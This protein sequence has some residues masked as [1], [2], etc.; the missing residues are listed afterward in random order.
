MAALSEIEK[1][2]A[3]YAENPEGRY[4]A[5]LADAYRKAGRADD[6]LQ[7]VTLGL[8]KHP[9]YLSAHI[10]LGR[11]HLDKKDD[12]AAMAA[13]QSVLGLD[14]EN[15]IA[16]KSLAEISERIGQ[17]DEARRWLMRLLAVDAMNTEAEADLQRLGGPIAEGEVAEAAAPVEEAADVS[18]ADVLAEDQPAVAAAEAKTEPIPAIALESPPAAALAS[19]AVP[20]PPAAP[21]LELEPAAFQAPAE[22]QPAGVGSDVVPFDDQL[23]WGAGERQSRA[24]HAEDVAGAE[25][26]PALTSSAIEFLGAVPGG[27]PSA[28]ASPPPP[29]VTEADTLR[30][31]ALP[32]PEVLEMQA[33]SR[34]AVEIDVGAVPEA[35][36]ARAPTPAEGLPLIM[37]EDVTPPEELRRPSAK[38]VQMVSPE[39]V[40]QVAAAGAP[41]EVMVT[42]TMGDL[43]L[44]Q[45]FRS[46]AAGVY[47]RLLA[48]RPDDAGLRAKLA[49]VESPP[50]RL[51]AAA[52]GTEAVG[53]W[54]RRIAGA[55][56]GAPVPEPAPPPPEGPAPMEAAFAEPEPEIPGEPAR[57]GTDQ[58]TLDH[59]FGQGA[60]PG[61]PDEAPPRSGGSAP[62][63]G[64]SFDEFFGSAP[65]SRETVRPNE[66]EA[67][68]QPSE[69]ELSEFTAWLH[70]LKR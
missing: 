41:G 43:Y 25:A 63:L 15:I 61:A 32:G 65:Q 55:S 1:L 59:V 17:G 6:A 19:E 69:D 12:G 54:L 68:A 22:A 49:A 37:P 53:A 31:E 35:P 3:R 45:G 34:G 44:R 18:F 50:P 24:I 11:C 8:Q 23:Q 42:E 62:S 52:L 10:V 57:P 64:T 30:M 2:E 51:S 39:P 33:P 66:G 5:P 7:L 48:Q 67:S 46:E 26:Q 9:D 13:F 20:S 14:A 29:E 40:A 16:L 27:G 47:R 28:P 58:F 36:A 38:Q 4:F 21:A 56:L 70:G 60:T